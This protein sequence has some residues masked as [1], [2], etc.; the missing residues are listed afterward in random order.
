MSPYHFQITFHP[1]DHSAFQ[2]LADE[3][4]AFEGLTHDTLVKYYGCEVHRVRRRIIVI[5]YI[6][7][8]CVQHGSR[9][10]QYNIYYTKKIH[11]QLNNI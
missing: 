11:T 10:I 1:N 7:Y 3:I 8:A 9:T 6:V 2:D 4:K 5:K